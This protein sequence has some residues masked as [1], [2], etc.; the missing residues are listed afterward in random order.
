MRQRLAYAEGTPAQTTYRSYLHTHIATPQGAVVLEK[1][2]LF[3]QRGLR[4]SLAQ[5]GTGWHIV[6]VELVQ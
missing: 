1:F 5:H 4:F 3:W 2:H 6:G